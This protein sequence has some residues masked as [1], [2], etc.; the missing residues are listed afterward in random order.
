MPAMGGGSSAALAGLAMPDPLVAA[1]PISAPAAA[2]GT[3]SSAAYQSPGQP[4]QRSASVAAAASNSPTTVDSVFAG[5]L[6]E[7]GNESDSWS[8]AGNDDFHA[9]GDDLLEAL[10]GGRQGPFERVGGR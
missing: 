5:Y 8:T 10:V 7:Q 1:S 9:P 2:A 4:A 3:S 6:A